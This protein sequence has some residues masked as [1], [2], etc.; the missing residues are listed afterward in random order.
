MDLEENSDDELRTLVT[1]LRRKRD[2]AAKDGA[3]HILSCEYAIDQVLD[4]MNRRKQ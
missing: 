3:R 1:I 2:E 4:E